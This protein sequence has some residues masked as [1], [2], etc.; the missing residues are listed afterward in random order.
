MPKYFF[1]FW[2]DEQRIDNVGEE[3]P[4][5]HAA[6]KEASETLSR[7]IQDIDGNLRPDRPY[8][9]EVIDEAGTPIFEMKVTA[10]CLG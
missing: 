3:L 8:R 6:W 1:N 9:L 4:D 7:I 2:D 5:R 10:K